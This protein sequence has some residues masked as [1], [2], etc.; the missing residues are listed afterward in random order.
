MSYNNSSSSSSSGS[1]ASSSSTVQYTSSG[2]FIPHTMYDPNTGLA[3][4]AKTEELHLQYIGLGYVHSNPG[5]SARPNEIDEEIPIAQARSST[6]QANTVNSLIPVHLRSGAQN[7]IDLL[8]DYYSY[9]NTDG[10]PSQ[11]INSILI[12]QDIDKTSLQYLDS[13]QKEVAMNVP[14]A[15]AFDRVSLY[16]KIVNYYL[17]KGS[18]DSILTFFKIFYDEAVIVSY[19]RELLFAP[20]MGNYDYDQINNT[21]K[22]L[23]GKSFPS[24]TD[25]IQDS[26]FWQNFS[27]VIETALPVE[28]WKSN[29][30][31]LV[32]PAGFKF[33]GII[34]ILMVRTNKW[35]GRHIRFDNVTRKYVLSDDY[36]PKIYNYPY[37]TKD[38]E[39]LDWLRSLIPPVLLK[40]VDRYSFNE[41]Y[42]TPTFQYGV[43]PMDTLINILI[44]KY[45]DDDRFNLFVDVVLNYIITEPGN[46]FL[47]GRDSY[48][49]DLKFLDSDG[50]SEFKDK[51]IG[52]SIDDDNLLSQRIFHNISAFINS[53]ITVIQE[54]GRSITK[55]VVGLTPSDTTKDLFTQESYNSDLKFIRNEECWAKDI[56][57]ITALSPWNSR[58]DNRRAGI[59]ISPRHVLFVEHSDYNLEVGDTIYFVTRNNVTISRQIIQ[60]KDHPVAGFASGDFNVAL[61]DSALP[62]DI[63]IMKVLPHNSYNYFPIDLYNEP[64]DLKFG[65]NYT[66]VDVPYVF[67]TDQEE[68]ACIK[69]LDS[70]NW[71]PA[72]AMDE[73]PAGYGTAQYSNDS[74]GITSTSQWGETTISGDSG[75]PIMMVLKGEAVLISMFTYTN[76]GPFLGQER[77]INEIDSLIS[78]VDTQEHD[79]QLAAVTSFTFE[80]RTYTKESNLAFD[81]PSYSG[82]DLPNDLTWNIA[83]DGAVWR[84]KVEEISQFTISGFTGSDAFLNG[85]YSGSINSGYTQ[86]SPANGGHI[87]REDIAAGMEDDISIVY[88]FWGIIDG[89]TTTQPTI[90]TNGITRNDSNPAILPLYHESFSFPG[91]TLSDFKGASVSSN[92]GTTLN[93]GVN[94]PYPWQTN[95][96]TSVLPN[97][98]NITP[99]IEFTPSGYQLT[100]FD[101]KSENQVEIF[102]PSKVIEGVDTSFTAAEGYSTT[103]DNLTSSHP[104]WEGREIHFD[105]SP[106]TGDQWINDP[107]NGKIFCTG[108]FKNIRT[109]KTLNARVGDIIKASVDFDFGTTPNQADD[110]RTFMLSLSDIGSYPDID[111]EVLNHSD[112]S[113]F[114]RFTENNN[115]FSQAKLMQRIEGAADIFV[116]ALGLN[117]IQGDRLRL[118]LEIDV[119]SSAAA[120]TV[121]VSYEN[122]SDSP[123]SAMNNN[124][125]VITGID[126]G[127]YNSLVARDPSISMTIQAGELTDTLIGTINVY[128][129]SFGNSLS[130]NTEQ[131]ATITPTSRIDISNKNISSFVYDTDTFTKSSSLINDRPRY[132]TS[133]GI[134]S[135]DGSNWSLGT[136]AGFGGIGITT[137][138][139]N[140]TPF[141]WLELDGTTSSDFSNLVGTTVIGDV[142][143]VTKKSF[144]ADSTK[145]LLTLGTGS[146]NYIEGEEITQTNAATG[147]TVTSEI[148][149]I[150]QGNIEILNQT[151]S[152]G[153]DTLFSTSENPPPDYLYTAKQIDAVDESHYDV[154]VTDDRNFQI[155]SDLANDGLPNGKVV[156]LK[157]SNDASDPLRFGSHRVTFNCTVND[158]PA[159]LTNNHLRLRYRANASGAVENLNVV[160]GANSFTFDIFDGTPAQ[161]LFISSATSSFDVS[162]SNLKIEQ[163]AGGTPVSPGNIVGTDSSASYT[164]VGSSQLRKDKRNSFDTSATHIQIEDTTVGSFQASGNPEWAYP[165]PHPAF[166]TYIRQ[167]G[168][169]NGKPSYSNV[170]PDDG[171]F[172]FV[173]FDFDPSDG[174]ASHRIFWN[175]SAWEAEVSRYTFS[176]S[177]IIH[178]RDTPYP[179]IESDGSIS[180]D[181]ILQS[182]TRLNGRYE[183]IYKSSDKLMFKKP[184]DGDTRSDSFNARIELSK[185]DTYIAPS[186]YKK[187]TENI[188]QIKDKF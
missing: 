160:V 144:E 183:L 112:L 15:V 107:A 168:L 54:T 83:W 116:G 119:K 68:K 5:N 164:M 184:D 85:I 151:A 94:T 59:A 99:S 71:Y 172:E 63:E 145:T 95:R 28:N 150:N 45:L 10:L 44:I 159:T 124:P 126:S 21:G 48:L 169:V 23:D 97:Y 90:I 12:E 52:E 76:S 120:S 11:E 32:H 170:V 16:K 82:L 154:I 117:S 7:F 30:L 86:I 157:K 29:F 72:R 6:T 174:Q 152:D 105:V 118:E 43:V 69:K 27:Y 73:S 33:F 14:D 178:T 75:N 77:N 102:T 148:L 20:S 4:N 78:D 70:L 108:L 25:K 109:A 149:A 62:D 166:D 153:S 80:N 106:D 122:I 110:E 92:V 114:I 37:Q 84:S 60:E 123:N 103:P 46:H 64:N 61:L 36:D 143:E 42:H 155:I 130:F 146:G 141:P 134:I 55:R 181:F 129:A 132:D 81:R 163:I 51:L 165:G 58:Q 100:Q 137:I 162:I 40:T 13:I 111:E 139:S 39:D 101:F 140:D 133:G 156:F 89:N 176:I 186:K 127:F 41:G 2:A 79:E 24:G 136:F 135:W 57:G 158:S 113:F 50:F 9:L 125:K 96:L 98:T 180:S 31:N 104:D 91:L 18:R 88:Y 171:S 182:D 34:S 26:Y 175:G 3:Y 49:Q 115:G 87:E 35:I 22:Y 17:T 93:D 66:D 53:E 65:S 173:D 167:P 131:L 56:K 67:H 179:W 147:V 138:N 47:R 38:V 142:V 187:Y 8:E 128:N 161:I 177:M 1:S 185:L 121:T 19:P 74:T 188:Q